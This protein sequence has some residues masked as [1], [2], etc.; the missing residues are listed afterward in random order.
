MKMP[1]Y[2]A[3]AGAVNANIQAGRGGAC[4]AYYSV[5]D[6]EAETIMMAQNPR[7]PAE[8]QNR[9]LHFAMMSNRLVGKKVAKKE[10]IFAFNVYTAPDLVAK[11]Y[12]GDQDGFESRY[13]QYENNPDFKKV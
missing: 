4:T 10:N 3:L 8:K 6:P 1:Y 9:D 5:F 12:S 7:T 11:F 2:A 13:N